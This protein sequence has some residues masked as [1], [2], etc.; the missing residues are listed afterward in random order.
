MR[1]EQ[2]AFEQVLADDA[3]PQRVVAIEHQ[4]LVEVAAKAARGQ[5]DAAGEL[6]EKRRRVRRRVAQVEA[7][8][9]RRGRTQRLDDGRG[10]DQPHVDEAGGHVAQRRIEAIDRQ[11]HRVGLADVDRVPIAMEGAHIDRRQRLRRAQR[12]RQPGAEIGFLQIHRVG[13][14]C[15]E[16]VLEGRQQVV[17]EGQQDHGLQARS[18]KA[19][20]IARR[21][22]V[23]AHLDAQAHTAQQRVLAQEGAQ[24]LNADV[25]RH[26]HGDLA[27][28]LDQRR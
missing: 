3:A 7:A 26:A 8:V 25:G 1:I 2:D 22:V 27:A 19:C 24:Q 16:L 21:V 4:R 6:V 11:L 13:R 23:V 14:Q 20:G 10:V 15:L 18:G 28:R 5:R 9:E 17:E 12:E